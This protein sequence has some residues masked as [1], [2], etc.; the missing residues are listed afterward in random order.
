MVESLLGFCGHGS[1]TCSEYCFPNGDAASEIRMNKEPRFRGL[2]GTTSQK[3]HPHVSRASGRAAN[4]ARFKHRNP[5][6]RDYH[7]VERKHVAGFGSLLSHQDILTPVL[8]P[9]LQPSGGACLQ[10]TKTRP[11]L[12]LVEM[13]A[14]D[15]KPCATP[16]NN[17]RPRLHG[18]QLFG[19]RECRA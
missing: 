16:A 8:G 6:Y 15:P 7:V 12:H 11:A 1:G 17:T 19:F 5:R 4:A 14:P 18:F 10:L 3:P 9:D 13:R 2:Y